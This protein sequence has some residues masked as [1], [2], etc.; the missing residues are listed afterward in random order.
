MRYVI[1][2]IDGVFRFIFQ[3]FLIIAALVIFLLAII[4]NGIFGLFNIRE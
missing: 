4:I 2:C 3:V 1:Q